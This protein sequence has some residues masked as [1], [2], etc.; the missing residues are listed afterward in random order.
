MHSQRACCYTTSAGRHSLLLQTHLRRVSPAQ[1]KHRSR[2]FS[3]PPRCC[4]AECQSCQLETHVTQIPPPPPEAMPRVP[5]SFASLPRAASPVPLAGHSRHAAAR[6]HAPP[7]YP[8]REA[9]AGRS[10]RRAAL[11]PGPV[12]RSP[13]GH[14]VPVS[15]HLRGHACEGCGC[16]GPRLPGRE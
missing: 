6:C 9:S 12:P 3:T 7:S 13:A 10:E 8:P 5:G 2:D 15:Q 1:Q 14:K 16:T 4:S 11:S